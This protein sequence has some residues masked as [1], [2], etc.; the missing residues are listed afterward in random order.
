MNDKL[1]AMSERMD[2]VGNLPFAG[3][4]TFLRFPPGRDLEG[5]ELVVLGAPMDVTTCYRPGCRFGPR[6]IR[7][8]SSFVLTELANLDRFSQVA[9]RDYGD[10][11]FAPG[12]LDHA[13]AQIENDARHI[14][15]QGSRLLTL[16][17]EHLIT[18][19][20]LR[21]HYQKYGPLALLQ[22]D[23]HS[24]LY[25]VWPR[26]YH[27]SVMA[28][29]LQEGLLAAERSLQVG[30]RSSPPPTAQG[31][32]L[33]YLSADWVLENGHKATI[34]R[35]HQAIAGHNCYLSYDIDFLDPAYAPGTGTPVVG[36]PTTWQSK[37]ILQGLAGLPFVGADVVELSP[38]FDPPGQP[39]ALAAAS[40]AYWIVEL[41][42]DGKK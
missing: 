3:P 7:E 37:Q 1:A 40:M 27:G 6:A 9:T 12:D 10:T 2:R 4:Q 32:E 20:L 42:L 15:S 19:P 38:P 29:A 16:G 17:G 18:L 8:M 11:W 35:I 31:P 30:I 13:L 36:G 5:V 24:D 25:D 21:A 34:E 14:L 26:P 33:P 28:Q 23:S 41:L 39:T 22:F